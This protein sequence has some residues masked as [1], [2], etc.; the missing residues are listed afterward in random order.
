MREGNDFAAKNAEIAKR[1]GDFTSDFTDF[2]DA[3]GSEGVLEGMNW[4]LRAE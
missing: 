4:A 2:A 3:D 1:D